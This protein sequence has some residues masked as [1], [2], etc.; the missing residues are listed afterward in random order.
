MDANVARAFNQ[1][2]MYVRKHDNA[3]L[4]EALILC[5][6]LFYTFDLFAF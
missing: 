3:L 6:S 1:L 5:L 4:K 2:D